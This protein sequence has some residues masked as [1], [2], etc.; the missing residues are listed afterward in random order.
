MPI[1]GL[2]PFVAGA[3][4]AAVLSSPGVRAQAMI[5][6]PQTTGIVRVLVRVDQTMAQT[7]LTVQTYQRKSAD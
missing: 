2:R 4:A 1:V 6:D 3:L 7:R 5:T